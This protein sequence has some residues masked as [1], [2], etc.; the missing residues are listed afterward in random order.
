MVER[1]TKLL[2]SYEYSPPSKA[3][4]CG[5]ADTWGIAGQG[6]QIFCPERSYCP[7]PTEIRTCDKGRYC[8]KGSS[9]SRRESLVSLRFGSGIVK[10]ASFSGSVRRSTD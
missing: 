1:Q 3:I 9:V 2:R 8:R 6:D 5:G 4:G 7:S 10:W